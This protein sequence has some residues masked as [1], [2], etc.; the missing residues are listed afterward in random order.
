MAESEAN[1][2][3]VLSTGETIETSETMDNVENRLRRGGESLKS[4]TN[5]QGKTQWV[6]V[7]HVVQLHERG[8]R[9]L[10]AL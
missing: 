4:V 10:R 7:A 5:A 3:I 2:V 6:N 9:S 8:E 1:C